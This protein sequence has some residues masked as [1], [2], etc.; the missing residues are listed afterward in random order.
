MY[1]LNDRL[2]A[3]LTKVNSLDVLSLFYTVTK[4]YIYK[5]PQ[6]HK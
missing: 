4:V 3:A 2:S 1:L 6:S 5:F